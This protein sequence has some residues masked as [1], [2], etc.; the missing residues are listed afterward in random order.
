MLIVGVRV[1]RAGL[2]GGG[3]ERLGMGR[4]LMTG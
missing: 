3:E 2:G 4:I 1:T